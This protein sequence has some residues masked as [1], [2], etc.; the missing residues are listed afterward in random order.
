[1]VL[2]YVSTCYWVGTV[3]VRVPVSLVMDMKETQ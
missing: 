2:L 3:V 1:M